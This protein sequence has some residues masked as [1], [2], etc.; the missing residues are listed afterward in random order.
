[1]SSGA[2]S[3]FSVMPTVR[4]PL[5]VRVAAHRADARARLADVAAQE[6]Q[7]RHHLHVLHAL[8]MLRQAHPVDRDHRIGL[9][10]HVGRGLERPARQRGLAFDRVPAERPHRR[11]ERVEAVRVLGDERRV[12]HAGRAGRHGHVV[13]R[14]HPLAHPHDRGGIAATAHLVVLRA[15]HGLTVRQ[16]LGR[17]LW[18]HEAD[19]AALAQR[20]EGHDLDAAP[21]GVLQLVQH[22][23]AVGAD[24]LAEEEDGVGVFEIVETDGADRHADGL[25]EG[26]R[27]ALV[28]HVRAVRQIVAAVHPRQQLIEVGGLERR[29]PGCVEHHRSGVELL[30]LVA[31]LVESVLPR[32]L[33]IA[34]ARRVPA[35][36]HGEPSDVLEGVVV[37]AA[38]FGQRVRVEEVGRR[39][40]AGD[41]P[42]GGLGAVLA[43][44]GRMRMRRLGPCA[45][46]AGESAGLVL[47]Q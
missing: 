16:H 36:R 28:A 38:Q 32:H 7:V 11:G 21:A 18:I 20:I 5:H 47:L 37:P 35:H 30:Q 6:Q 13:E 40:L 33:A 34:I 27:R 19:Q 10:V 4:C 46:H 42:G 44:L 31:D 8:A 2:S 22:P 12:D 17:R 15:D 24:V 14:D 3:G 9:Q 39:P 26:H 23:R 29:A 43:E 45:T 41:L 1:L 25:R